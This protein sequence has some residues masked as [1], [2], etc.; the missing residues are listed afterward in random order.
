MA[1]MG[2]HRQIMGDKQIGEIV[3]ALQVDQQIDHLGLDRDVK[4]RDRLVAHDQAWSERQ[5][6]GDTDALA[7]A[8]GKLMRIVAHL[9][10][11]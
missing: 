1:D 11:P 3:L 4:R 9:I 5:C 7:L 6:T 8:A 2:D 10:R